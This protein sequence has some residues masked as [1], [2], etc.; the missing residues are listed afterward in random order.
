MGYVTSTLPLIRYTII[1]YNRRGLFLKLAPKSF[2]LFLIMRESIMKQCLP[3]GVG[4]LLL[5]VSSF[6]FSLLL[7]SFTSICT[8]WSISV[9]LI[10]CTR[11]WR[12]C[13][14]PGTKFLSWEFYNLEV[15]RILIV[16]FSLHVK[17]IGSY[18]VDCI[19]WATVW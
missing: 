14:E 1:R 9:C 19:K 15:L 18:S 10:T 8:F 17:T 12:C 3:R 6:L 11:F 4:I 7:S 16:S 2:V 13:S 5:D